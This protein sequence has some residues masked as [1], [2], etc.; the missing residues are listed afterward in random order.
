[1]M[2]VAM[3]MVVMAVLGL[4]GYAGAQE[5]PA[6]APQES[7][8]ATRDSALTEND[9]VAYGKDFILPGTWLSAEQFDSLTILVSNDAPDHEQEAARKFERLW[10]SYTGTDVSISRTRGTGPTVWI[11]A[12]GVPMPILSEMKLVSGTLTPEEN[13]ENDRELTMTGLGNYGFVLHTVGDSLFIVGGGR[14]GTSSGVDAFFQR[15]GEGLKS[16]GDVKGSVP[17]I[18]IERDV[19]SWVWVSLLIQMSAGLIGLLGVYWLINFI[20]KED[21]PIPFALVLSGAAIVSCV[22]FFALFLEMLTAMVGPE[23]RPMAPILTFAVC[24]WPIRGYLTMLSTGFA[25]RGAYFVYGDPTQMA[26]EGDSEYVPPQVFTMRE[27]VNDRIKEY[28]A[29]FSSNPTSPRPLFEAAQ[30]L[31]GNEYYDEA[32]EMYREIIQIF[33]RSEGI[34]AESN[35]RLASLHENAL[36]NRK[37]AQEIFKR[38]VERAPESEYGKLAA[39]RLEEV[40][41]A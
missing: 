19:P 6:P 24:F 30:L 32:A 16:V 9:P 17:L 26:V 34:W 15:Y 20:Y 5:E 27:D 21:V 35:F 4:G 37:G 40:P 33:H 23:A 41:K 29:I 18:H 38:V 12:I 22:W 31:E 8:G 11:G 13:L 7:E 28:R 10:E 1:M 36:F 39:A 3:S 2:R 25:R 14:F